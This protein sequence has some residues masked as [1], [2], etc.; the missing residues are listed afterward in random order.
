LFRGLTL[1]YRKTI[2]SKYSA[3]A[4]VKCHYLMSTWK[5]KAL[6]MF[7]VIPSGIA[8]LWLCLI[9]SLVFVHGMFRDVPSFL[10]SLMAVTG[11]A[12]ISIALWS[13]FRYPKISKVSIWAYG[14]GCFALVAGGFT[15]FA[16]SYLYYLSV[17]CLGSAGLLV[18][19]EYRRS[20]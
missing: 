17:L 10:M 16:T 11:L 9:G 19:H 2:H 18:I 1:R 5:R 6:L 20:T 13:V 7:L 4:G 8:W 15:G 3:V 12:C 14:I